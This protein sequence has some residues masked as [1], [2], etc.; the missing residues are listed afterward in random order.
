MS[1]FSGEMLFFS[2]LKRPWS[3]FS[4]PF[5]FPSYYHSVIYRVVN[6]ISVGRNLSGFLCSHWV[7]IS[8]CQRGLWCWHVLF[9]PLF[10]VH[11]FCQTSSLGCNALWEVISFL[12]ILSICLSLSLVHLRKGPEYLTR[13]NSPGI[14]SFDKISARKLCLE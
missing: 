14:Y 3:C 8:M 7:V 11:T 12:V 2:R 1:R 6:I 4:F 13:G 9:L 10:L 5:L